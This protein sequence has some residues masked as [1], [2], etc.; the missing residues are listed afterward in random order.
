SSRAGRRTRVSRPHRPGPS[1]ETCVAA[2]YQLLYFRNLC[3][4]A[5]AVPSPIQGERALQGGN[6]RL[7]LL[8]VAVHPHGLVI[9]TLLAVFL[10]VAEQR[11]LP[12]L[13]VFP[14]ARE[15]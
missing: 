7:Q 2:S 5:Q 6:L 11:L 12:L 8:D 3:C 14:Q 10:G 13:P 15:R 1:Q 4:S 9:A